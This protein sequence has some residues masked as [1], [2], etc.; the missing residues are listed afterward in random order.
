MNLHA[1]IAKNREHPNYSKDFC[2]YLQNYRTFVTEF[3]FVMGLEINF[4]LWC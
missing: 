2:T 4:P 3:E 1:K